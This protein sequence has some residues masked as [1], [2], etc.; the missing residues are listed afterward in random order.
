MDQIP[1]KIFTHFIRL[2][3][4]LITILSLL[5]VF[6]VLIFPKIE[7]SGS[8]SILLMVAII[9]GVTSIMAAGNIY[10]DIRDQETDK[11]N[12]SNQMVIGVYIS[13]NQAFRWYYLLNFLAI[14]IGS[15]LSLYTWSTTPLL[16][17]GVAIFLLFFYS[18]K[19]KGILIIGNLIISLLCALVI[20]LVPLYF[21]PYLQQPWYRTPDLL[22][23]I[24]L[25]GSLAFF[26]TMIRELVKDLQ[27]K[28]GDAIASIKTVANSWPLAKVK[29]FGYFLFLCL[30]LQ[31]LGAVFYFFNHDEKLKGF[32]LMGLSASLCFLLLKFVLASATNQFATL[33]RWMKLYILQGLILLLFWL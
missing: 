17:F 15:A 27:D 14:V 33:S 24:S 26:T 31:L 8:T 10:N 30:L 19:G 3:N 18:K 13:E 21:S 5:L 1:L 12:R 9:T 22:P 20:F 16:T 25:L 32:Y 11:I 4:L 28:T 29:I 23:V 6:L 2:P 7:S